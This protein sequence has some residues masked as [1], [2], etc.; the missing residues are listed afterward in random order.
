MDKLIYTRGTYSNEIQKVELDVNE[1]I[2]IHKIENRKTKLREKPVRLLNGRS[3]NLQLNQAIT[4]EEIHK[5]I[6]I[7]PET[8]P[9]SLYLANANRG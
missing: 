4:I 3:T 6:I 9:K 5:T 2:D 7:R 1:N 8:S